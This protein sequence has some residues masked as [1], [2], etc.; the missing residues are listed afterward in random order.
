MRI[1]LQLERKLKS[2]LSGIA[3]LLLVAAPC[4]AQRYSFRSYTQ[5]MGNLNVVSMAQDHTGY[6]WVGTQNGLYRY[7]GTEFRNFGAAEGLPERMIQNLFVSPDDTLWAV[8]TN[9]LYFRT[10]GGKFSRVTPPNGA[11]LFAQVSNTVFTATGPNRVIALAQRGAVELDQADGKWTAQLMAL[12]G[13]SIASVLFGS[14]GTLWY[15]C[16]RDLCKRSGDQ[17]TRLAAPLH[18]PSEK[19]TSLLFS[20]DGHLWI[21]GAE[22]VGE[23]DVKANT[24]IEHALPGVH[25]PEAYPQLVLDGQGRVLTPVGAAIAQW[26]RSQWRLVNE[27]HG[28][29]PF[30]I[31]E[32]FVDREGSV[33]LSE[34]GHGLQRWVGQDHWEAFTAADG[35]SND[36][37]WASLRDREGRLW[38][39]TESG[40]DWIPQG[41]TQPKHWNQS[42]VMTARTG[43]IA[44]SSD[45][46]IWSGSSVGA[47]TRID[48][49]SL[50]GQQW[51]LPEVFDIA[52]DHK[53]NV[54]VA[55]TSGLYLAHA[56][57]S[58]APPQLVNPAVFGDAHQRFSDLCVDAQDR[59]WAAADHGLFLLDATGWHRI[60]L[61]NMTAM[62][63]TIA[64]DSH[65]V[66]W[67][68]GPAIDLMRVQVA[69]YR[70]AR[71]THFSKPPLLSE[72]VVAL[73]VDHRGWVWVGEDA[74]ISVFDGKTWHSFTQDD[75]LIW[76]D[77]DSYALAED[78]DG[79]IWVGTSGGLSHLT[80]PQTATLT[81]TRAPAFSQ[82]T[83]GGQTL[84]DGQSVLWQADSL[85]IAMTLLSFKGNQDAA[86]RYR[87]LGSQSPGWVVTRDMEVQYQRLAPGSYRFEVEE[88]DQADR[89]ISP[90]AGISFVVV[91]QWWQRTGLRWIS[92]GCC[93]L[94]MIVIWRRRIGALIKQK[95]HLEDAVH[96]RTMDLEREKGE[97]MRTREQMRHFAEHDDLTGLWNHRIIVERLAIE[98]DRSR[99]EG[100]PVSVILAD[101]DYFKHIN[102]TYGHPAGDRV[103]QE[104]SAIF[105]N[106]VRTY[107]WV[108]R[109][110]GE[111]FLLILP[112]SGFNHARQRAEELRLAIQAAIVKDGETAIPITASFGVASGFPDNSEDLIRKADEALYRA[113]HNGRNCVMATE[114]DARRMT[115]SRVS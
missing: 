8:T 49:K 74:G 91:P 44:E 103:L 93:V 110:G 115:I 77:T 92:G 18:L 27:N 70:A 85:Q 107:D 23:I 53:G 9:G 34:V 57:S 47:L 105:K 46:A 106:A 26:D 33:W 29:A 10:K 11:G 65:G 95:R 4:L 30:E 114:V 52:A 14:D 58:N 101:M 56:L 20:K 66:V 54:W 48:A 89:V 102:D 3:A 60:D 64:V 62:P 37:V 88:V 22:H 73:M 38:V 13:G 24:Y 79:S 78:K 83:Y 59:V 80:S 1:P 40:L 42:G 19:W 21:R 32:I 104:A 94:V 2:L 25:A 36:L 76:N 71:I 90:I 17:T 67:V 111:E 39:G 61:G 55:S 35:L 69:G 75:G 113:K 63:D 112:G 68:S 16:D 108:G 7:D 15:G 43:S 51:K 82:I 72:Q 41:Q 6:L 31:E 50:R 96:M 99:R 97:L 12:E 28:L 100:L 5:G 81:A 84:S 45:G 87:L 109:Y 98:V 86:I